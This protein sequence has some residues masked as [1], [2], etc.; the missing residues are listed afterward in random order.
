MALRPDWRWNTNWDEVKR[1]IKEG[2]DSSTSANILS[3][4][5]SQTDNLDVLLSS[6]AS[7]ATLS[8]RASEATLAGIKAQTDKLTFDAANRLAVQNPPNID[9]LLSTRSSEATLSALS[10]S[11]RVH[12]QHSI[13]KF[14]LNKLHYLQKMFLLVLQLYSLILIQHTEMR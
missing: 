13:P 6:R 5:R 8:T 9:V 3:D 12:Y 2:I 11:V 1:A 7:E 10:S 14:K 4:I